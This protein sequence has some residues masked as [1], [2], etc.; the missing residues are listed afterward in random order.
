[1]RYKILKEGEE[2]NTIVSDEAFVT[3]FCEQNGYTFEEVVVEPE[4]VEVE[5]T[6]AEILNA[7]LGVSE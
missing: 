3:T 1:M 2:I 6:T 4:T 7:M 5:P